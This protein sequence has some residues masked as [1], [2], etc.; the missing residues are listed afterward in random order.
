MTSVQ[1]DFIPSPTLLLPITYYHVDHFYVSVYPI[2]KKDISLEYHFDVD[3]NHHKYN[4]HLSAEEVKKL[5]DRVQFKEFTLKVPYDYNLYT[6]DLWLDSLPIG[7][8]AVILHPN[9]EWDTSTTLM[10]TILH[11][12]DTKVTY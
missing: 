5:G 10:N 11:V 12:T 3:S 4:P 9:A 8:Y 7:Y 6:T 1:S 2:I